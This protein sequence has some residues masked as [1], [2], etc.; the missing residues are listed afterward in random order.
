[1]ATAEMIRK[2]FGE[3][4]AEVVIQE[5]DPVLLRLRPEENIFRINVIGKRGGDRKFSITT[6]CIGNVEVFDT[7][8][9][10]KHLLL[11]F[12]LT[13]KGRK[14]IDRFLCGHDERD[15]FSATVLGRGALTTV[16]AAKESLKPVEVLQ[17]QR[18]HGVRKNKLLDRHTKGSHRQGEWFFIPEEPTITKS[19]ILLHNEPFSRARGTSHWAEEAIR[20]GG[21]SAW[22][23]NNVVL[24]DEEVKKIRASED[25]F[26][27]RRISRRVVGATLYVRGKITHPDHKTL[28]LKSWH[29]VVGNSEI[30]STRNAFID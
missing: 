2:K 24:T 5:P 15:W 20:V 29:K 14:S 13:E 23:R 28:H 9:K 21:N 10:E 17:S 12:K 16:K 25:S 6:N 22:V 1:M 30:S 7:V 18:K 4:G 8:P 26:G 3:I 11:G 19:D 27:I